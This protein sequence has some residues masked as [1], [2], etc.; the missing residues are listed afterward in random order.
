MR[1][2]QAARTCYWRPAIGLLMEYPL[3]LGTIGR[4]FYFRTRKKSAPKGAD[5][6]SSERRAA[7][8]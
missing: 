5:G 2:S 6:A 1:R 7:G 4:Q 3:F 8:P